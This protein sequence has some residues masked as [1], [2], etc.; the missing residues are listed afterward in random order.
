M[1]RIPSLL[2]LPRTCFAFISMELSLLGHV[3]SSGY[4]VEAGQGAAA[5]PVCCASVILQPKKAELERRTRNQ[6]KKVDESWR[7][8][9]NKNTKKTSGR[10]REKTNGVRSNLFS[11]ELP[12]GVRSVLIKV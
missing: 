7:K 9:A 10:I 6:K 8:E 12:D 4:D 11:F 5:A 3:T 2:C 1:R